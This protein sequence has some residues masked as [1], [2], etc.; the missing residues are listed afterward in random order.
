MKSPLL[1][2]N[3]LS[4][5]F[6]LLLYPAL[7]TSRAFAESTEDSDARQLVR[8]ILSRPEYQPRRASEGFFDAYKR[9]L[10]EYLENIFERLTRWLNGIEGPSLGNSSIGRWLVDALLLLREIMYLVVIVTVVSVVIIC[11]YKILLPYIRDKQSAVVVTKRSLPEGKAETF[12][13][14]AE[15]IAAR[16]YGEALA[17]MHRALR[18]LFQHYYN[19]PLSATDYEVKRELP[20]EAAQAELFSEIAKCFES[21]SYADSAPEPDTINTL[22]S[23]FE[24]EGV[25]S[26]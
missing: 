26:A 1:T 16:R 9:L 3:G 7:V 12:P 22:Y 10:G 23:R 24:R 13:P 14:V 21:V 15:L 2:P 18:R 5:I 17:A 4:G 19:I 25:R 6:A 8:E 11:A 20:P